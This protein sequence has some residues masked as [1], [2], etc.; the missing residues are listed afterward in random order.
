[1]FMRDKLGL[2]VFLSAFV[3][4]ML[5]FIF[6]CGSPGH[7]FMFTDSF[8]YD[9]VAVNLLEH[10][11]FFQSG[12]PEN[13]EPYTFRTPVYPFYL[14]ILYALGGRNVYVPIIFQIIIGSL[15]CLL[16]YQLGKEL[17][18]KIGGLVAGFIMVFEPISILYSNLVLTETLFVFIFTLSIFYF[19]RFIYREQR[20]WLFLSGCFLGLSALTRPVA[21]YFFIP[22]F[23]VSLIIF[24]GNTIKRIL[25]FGVL[26][27]A[28]LLFITPWFIRN[29]LVLDVFPYFSSVY[30]YN[31]F[32]RTAISLECSVCNIDFESAKEKLEREYEKYLEDKEKSMN[33][34]EELKSRRRFATQ[35]ISQHPM[36]YINLHL[37]NFLVTYGST[38]I[39]KYSQLLGIHTQIMDFGMDVKTL[40]SRIKE[41]FMTRT[42]IQVVFMIM[43]LLFSGFIYLSAC[44][45]V[46][47]FIKANKDFPVLIL[48]LFI[49]IYFAIF[50]VPGER[51]VRFRLPVMPYIAILAS[52]GLF[53]RRQS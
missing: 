13:F 46:F 53:K 12:G 9:N 11:Q 33:L 52:K 26:L 19:L 10:R 36:K 34:V 42:K 17:T 20:K 15:T 24:K 37:K 6:V 43:S 44:V 45:G 4:R 29:Y 3:I 38:G 1:V 48:F 39:G 7:S 40:W 8:D 14:A 5:L 16:V 18:G 50:I 51:D 27:S 49:I 35:K 21:L 31:L 30:D 25:N 28:F 41:I 2:F 23:I 47:K 22:M 32:Y